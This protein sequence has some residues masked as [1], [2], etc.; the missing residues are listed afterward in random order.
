MQLISIFNKGILFLLCVTDFYS[1]YACVVPLKDQRGITITNA[2]QKILD[3][4]D[5]KQNKIWIDKD[6]EFYKDQ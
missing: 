5:L 2:L 6:S 4:S 3:G 1:K